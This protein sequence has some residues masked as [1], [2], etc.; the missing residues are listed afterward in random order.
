M[1]QHEKEFGK[2][3]RKAKK[4]MAQVITIELMAYNLMGDLTN[5]MNIDKAE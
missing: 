3:D 2:D 4:K 5:N 1:H